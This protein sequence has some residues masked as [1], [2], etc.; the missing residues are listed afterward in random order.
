M[1]TAEH[2][3]VTELLNVAQTTGNTLVPIGVERIERQRDAGI[4]ARVDLGTV[5]HW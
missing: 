4:T 5:K 1:T 2:V 3:T